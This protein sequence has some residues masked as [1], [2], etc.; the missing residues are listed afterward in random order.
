MSQES[1]TT[2]NCNNVAAK[3]LIINA[4]FHRRTKHIDIKYYYVR[5]VYEKGK[6]E[7]QHVANEGQLADIFTKP[8]VQEK[9]MT[10]RNELRMG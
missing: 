6:L 3:K 4:V 2:L 10:N 1:P 8:L 7:I 5:Q 9:F